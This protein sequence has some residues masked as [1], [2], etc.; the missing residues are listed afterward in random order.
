MDTGKG[1][2]KAIDLSFGFPE[3]SVRSHRESSGKDRL[4]TAF[5]CPFIPRE[6]IDPLHVFQIVFSLVARLAFEPLSPVLGPKA[7]R[8]D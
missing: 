1:L 3:T 2:G 4:T 6:V 5:P 7:F 8:L